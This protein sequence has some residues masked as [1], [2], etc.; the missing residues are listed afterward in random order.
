[1]PSIKLR[2]TGFDLE[3]K[4]PVPIEIRGRHDTCILPR[5]LAAAEAAAAVGLFDLFIA[6]G[7]FL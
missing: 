3:K 6:D 5:G 4:E 7:R 2:Q 1:V